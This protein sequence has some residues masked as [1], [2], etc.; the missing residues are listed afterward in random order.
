MNDYVNTKFMPERFYGLD[1]NM[2]FFKIKRA[3]KNGD[4]LV[5][6]VLFFDFKRNYF[7]VNLGNGFYGIIYLNNY[8]IYPF[9]SSVAN[10]QIGKTICACVKK[11]SNR[12]IILSRKANMLKTFKKISNMENEIFRCCIT[13]IVEYGVFVDIGHGISG[14]I[15]IKNFCRCRVKDVRDIGFNIGYFI[16]AKISS[17]DY[18][19]YQVQLVYKDLFENLF[20]SCQCGD[21]IAVLVLNPVQN[22]SGYYVYINPNT[23]A[24]LNTPKSLEPIPFGT[25]VLSYVRNPGIESPKLHLN[26]ISFID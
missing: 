13:G 11:I 15:H 6:I 21:K 2:S 9:P 18:N 8:S 10:S 20:Y 22:N 1:N 16:N 25:K 12:R 5:G 26:F 4:F 19:K 23:F 7:K 24:I 17:I 14:L 3:K